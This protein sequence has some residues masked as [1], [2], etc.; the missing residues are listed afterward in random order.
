MDK[1]LTETQR[2]HKVHDSIEHGELQ[3]KEKSSIKHKI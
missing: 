1:I 3:S 2:N